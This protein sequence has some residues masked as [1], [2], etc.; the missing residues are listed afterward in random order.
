MLPFIDCHPR[1]IKYIFNVLLPILIIVEH[2]GPVNGI[3]Q[4]TRMFEERHL[5]RSTLPIFIHKR[6]EKNISPDYICHFAPTTSELY[7]ASDTEVD[8]IYVS[9][10]D[11]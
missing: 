7:D 6:N 4:C 10:G 3:S 5:F 9:V 11:K 8:K 1:T 2:K